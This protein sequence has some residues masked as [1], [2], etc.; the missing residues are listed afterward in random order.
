M[1][2]SFDNAE[3]LPKKIRFVMDV[4][5]RYSEDILIVCCNCA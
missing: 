4:S 5:G 1:V 2:T 3:E